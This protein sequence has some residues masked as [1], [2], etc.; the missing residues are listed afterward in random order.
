MKVL[1]ALLATDAAV[2]TTDRAQRLFKLIAPLVQDVEGADEDTDE[3]VR[4]PLPAGCLCNPVQQTQQCKQEACASCGCTPWRHASVPYAHTIALPAA[5]TG[6]TSRTWQPAPCTASGQTPWTSTLPSCG[7]QPST[8]WQGANGEP[9]PAP[10]SSSQ[11]CSSCAGYRLALRPPPPAKQCA[12]LVDQ[13]T[14]GWLCCHACLLPC[15]LLHHTCMLAASPPCNWRADQPMQ[16]VHS[17]PAWLCAG[18]A[19]RDHHSHS[20]RG[21]AGCGRA[22]PAAVPGRCR[23]CL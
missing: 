23:G 14:A 17:R 5:R 1:R 22:G 15:A 4:S 21:D 2:D 16:G 10:P 18:A 9:G 7:W 11:P 3:D 19:V 6:R 8:S 12:C 20:A 13:A